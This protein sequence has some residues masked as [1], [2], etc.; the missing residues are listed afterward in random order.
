MTKKRKIII[1][2]QEGDAMPYCL[3]CRMVLTKKEEIT[4]GQHIY[5]LNT[6][7]D[8]WYD[9]EVEEKDT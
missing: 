9:K 5:C 7:E 1:S 8:D 2:D 6:D 4:L 3:K